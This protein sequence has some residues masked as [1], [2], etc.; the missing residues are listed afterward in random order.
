MKAVSVH[1]GGEVFASISCRLGLRGQLAPWLLGMATLSG[2]DDEC[3]MSTECSSSASASELSLGENS[4]ESRGE[5]DLRDMDV[6]SNSRGGM[7]F[8]LRT[9]MLFH[10]ARERLRGRASGWWASAGSEGL[11]PCCCERRLNASLKAGG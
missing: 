7:G 5:A 8:Q 3:A 9:V 2:R 11:K 10:E 1:G 6:L 4:L